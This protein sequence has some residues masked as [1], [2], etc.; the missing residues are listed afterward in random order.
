MAIVHADRVKETTTTTGTGT[1]NLAG[2]EAG[3]R[4]FVAGVGN[5]NQCA[6][7]VENGTDWEI[8]LGTVTDAAPDTLSRDALLSSSTGSA[9]NW[10][11]GTKNIFAVNPAKVAPG[12]MHIGTL[13]LAS[14]GATLGPLIAPVPL[15][16]IFGSAFVIAPGVVVPRL[17]LGQA[18]IDTGS[19]YASAAAR[20]NVNP[21]AAPSLRGWNIW[22]AALASGNELLVNFHIRK[23]AAGRVARATWSAG[24][25]SIAAATAP[26]MEQGAG[27]WVDTSNLIQR[28]ELHGYSAITGTADANMT[29]GT[30]LQVYGSVELTQ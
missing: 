8:N 27:I 2:A 26:I 3:F 14:N 16:Y 19:N 29:A 6:Y 20:P 25:I 23:P 28:I 24:G 10:G 4:T 15:T 1:Y 17:L 7:C 13:R 22:Q 11:A 12:I 5:G 21:V 30:E 9:I 18:S